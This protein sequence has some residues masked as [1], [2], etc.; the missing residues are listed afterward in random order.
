MR[1][2]SG[3]LGKGL[4]ADL[5]AEELAGLET[6]GVVCAGDLRFGGLLGA[7]R[8]IEITA[9]DSA[10]KVIAEFSAAAGAV[11]TSGTT[12]RSWKTEQGTAHHLIDPRTGRPAETGVVQATAIAPTTS[13]AEYRAKAALLGGR[14]GA[15]EWLVDGGAIVTD[16]LEILTFGPVVKVAR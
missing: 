9:P 4:A 8:R 1:L 16:D 3:G 10:G 5:V 15:S 7:E 12:R 14:G 13:E 11:A 2:D 6:W